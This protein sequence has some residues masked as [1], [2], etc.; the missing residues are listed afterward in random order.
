MI[1][2]AALPTDD[3]VVDD[4]VRELKTQDLGYTDEELHALV[5]AGAGAAVAILRMSDGP[6]AEAAKP[7][8]E[9]EGGVVQAIAIKILIPTLRATSQAIVMEQ[10]IK[11]MRRG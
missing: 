9:S 10:F 7:F 4:L 2:F 11:M 5:S 1:K 6:M 8:S 3:R